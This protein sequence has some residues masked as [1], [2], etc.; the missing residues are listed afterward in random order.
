VNEFLPHDLP[1]D[2]DYDTIVGLV[3]EIFE[4]IPEVGETKEFNGYNFTILKKVGQNIEAVK[5]ELLLSDDQ[6]VNNH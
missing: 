3:S 4:K 1:E 6:T 2:E 5:L